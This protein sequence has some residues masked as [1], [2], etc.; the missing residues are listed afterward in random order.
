MDGMLFEATDGHHH[1]SRFGTGSRLED[2]IERTVITIECLAANR[3]IMTVAFKELEPHVD[4]KN[5]QKNA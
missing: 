2:C 5:R 4:I 1:D 3:T